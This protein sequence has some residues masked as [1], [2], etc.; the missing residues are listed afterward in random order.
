[1]DGT[2]QQLAVHTVGGVVPAAQPLMKIVPRQHQIQVEAMVENK[3]VGFIKEGQ[4]AAVKVDAYQYTKYGLI[5]AHVIHISRDAIRDEKR[6]LIYSV[7][8]VLEKSS[9]VIEGR[10][11][12]LNPGMSVNVDIKTGERRVIEYI[13]SPLLKLKKESLGER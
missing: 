7:I 13:L 11:A 5:P 3:D 4:T 6:G 8:V 10:E 2:V 1:V 9:M 12:M